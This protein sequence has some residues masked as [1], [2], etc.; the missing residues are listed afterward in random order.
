MIIDTRL[1]TSII[2]ALISLQI[3]AESHF[4]AAYEAAY[5]SLTIS[6]DSAFMHARRCVALAEKDRNRAQ[7]AKSYWMLG[8]IYQ[9][10]GDPANAVR[11]YY[12][13][14]T[15]YQKQKDPVAV[16]KLSENIGTIALEQGLYDMA[17][18]AYTQ[19]LHFAEKMDYQEQCEAWYDLGLAHRA[20]QDYLQSIKSFLEAWK[21]TELNR[22]TANFDLIS[23]IHNE[24]GITYKRAAL[25]LR[26]PAFLD[27]AARMY[28]IA[29]DFAQT[30]MSTFHPTVNMGLIQSLKHRYDSALVWYQRALPTG[31]RIPSKHVLVPVYNNIGIAYYHTARLE[32]ADSL[33]R[34]S[35]LCN[36]QATPADVVADHQMHIR[37]VNNQELA[38]S[39]AYLDSLRTLLP[40]DTYALLDRVRDMERQKYEVEAADLKKI[41]AV[42][43][44]QIEKEVLA[45]QKVSRQVSYAFVSGLVLFGGL[46]LLAM[47]KLIRLRKYRMRVMKETEKLARKFRSPMNCF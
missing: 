43:L 24:L 13:A 1:I 32:L 26:E 8:Y 19:R 25:A 2:F 7:L 46:L 15:I 44:Q 11:Y 45:D 3:H 29:L 18:R 33:F 36:M 31:L 34:L 28:L 38:T 16:V 39:Y 21:I 10:A 47:R 27:S 40:A 35:I 5:Q 12:G 42:E 17:I 20:A 30:D 37:P 6:T 9:V 41:I 4:D 23:R 22:S 14:L